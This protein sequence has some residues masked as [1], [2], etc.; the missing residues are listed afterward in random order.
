VKKV[1]NTEE[2]QLHQPTINLECYRY[3][4]FI[5]MLNSLDLS[6]VIVK[7]Q[8]C[9]MNREFYR[10]LPLINLWMM[11]CYNSCSTAAQPMY[12]PVIPYKYIGDYHQLIIDVSTILQCTFDE[13][14]N[15]VTSWKLGEKCT[16]ICNDLI[17][18]VN[19]PEYIGICPT[20]KEIEPNRDRV[21]ICRTGGAAFVNVTILYKS[22]PNSPPLNNKLSP[23]NEIIITQIRV[24]TYKLEFT[25]NYELSVKLSKSYNSS[26]RCKNQ[27]IAILLLRYFWYC[28]SNHQLALHPTFYEQLNAKYPISLELFAS[29]INRHFSN[30]AS[31]YNDIEQY[32]GSRGSFPNIRLISSNGNSNSSIGGDIFMVANPPF[33]ETIML[34]MAEQ[35]ITWLNAQYTSAIGITIITILPQWG[36]LAPF[37]AFELLKA[38][39]ILTKCYDVPQ[40]NALFVNYKMHRRKALSH[41]RP[42]SIYILI[43]QN[44]VARTKYHQLEYD[45]EHIIKTTIGGITGRSPAIPPRPP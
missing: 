30:Y 7:D 12:D 3:S 29:G 24:D 38:S 11:D 28:D 39:G 32:F 10:I 8:L 16:A 4:K 45:I 41:I 36:E 33:D 22:L 25:I 14:R 23:C 42:C 40:Q 19:S 20:A 1:M 37:D 34:R 6:A 43:L 31:L 26:L 2:L 17:Q 18:Y 27:D 15:M 35:F 5:E 44:T 21:V 13:S 9:N